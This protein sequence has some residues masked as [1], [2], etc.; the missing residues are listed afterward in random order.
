MMLY[1]LTHQQ[2]EDKLETESVRDDRP[3][4]EVYDD[5]AFYATILKV[6]KFLRRLIQPSFNSILF[7]FMNLVIH[8]FLGVWDGG[9]TGR[10]HAGGGPRSLADIQEES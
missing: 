7:T 1:L 2:I 6:D 9:W 10:I 3:T 8:Y 4:G 5:R